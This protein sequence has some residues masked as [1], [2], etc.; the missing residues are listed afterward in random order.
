ME[1]KK[2][3]PEQIAG[4]EDRQKK[5]LI[6][7][8]KLVKEQELNVENHQSAYINLLKNLRDVYFNRINVIKYDVDGSTTLKLIST[9]YDLGEI[10]LKEAMTNIRYICVDYSNPDIFSIYETKLFLDINKHNSYEVES[11]L[12][13]STIIVEDAKDEI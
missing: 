1:K 7:M 13:L 10:E 3:S 9:K 8:G 12:S 5:D 2:V 4:W 11:Y 6:A